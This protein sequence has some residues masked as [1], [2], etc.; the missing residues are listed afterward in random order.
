MKRPDHLANEPGREL[1]SQLRNNPIT[2]QR[3]RH[4]RL[5]RALSRGLPVMREEAD[6]VAGASNSPAIIADLR[7]S[8][9]VIQCDRVERLDRDGKTCRP[10]CYTLHP[11]QLEIAAALAGKV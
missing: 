5:L 3:P 10:G 8:G 4:L 6:R 2:E 7:A 9:W 1:L 11:D